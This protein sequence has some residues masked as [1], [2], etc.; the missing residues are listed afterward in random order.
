MADRFKLNF[1]AGDKLV[2]LYIIIQLAL[3]FVFKPL[4]RNSLLIFYLASAG[5]IL[6]IS[7]VP[8]LEKRSPLH[9]I[10]S[11]YPLIM[12]YVFYRILGVQTQLFGFQSHDVIFYSL[13]KQLLDIYPTFALQRVMEV[14]LNE[15]SYAL[16]CLGLVLPIW[17]IVKLYRQKYLKSFDNFILALSISCLICLTIIS[18]FPVSGPGQ[19]LK[20]FYYLGIYGPRFAAIVPI[21]INILT[22]GT[23][24]FPAIY[25]CLLTISSYYLWDFGNKYVFLSFTL[26]ISVFWGGVYL[27]YH[28]LADALVALLIAF[29]GATIASFIYYMKHGPSTE[30]S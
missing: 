11:I 21:L 26:L 2:L 3:I 13:E 24:S 29:L 28:Y 4:S 23:A 22:P 20:E 16:Y 10:R 14:W 6:F 19:A 1:Y 5:S 8:R 7:A 27:R 25:F 15:L 30:P 18:V 12:I 17:V 9:F